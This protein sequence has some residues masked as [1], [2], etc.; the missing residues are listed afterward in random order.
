VGEPGSG[1]ETVARVVH[2]ASAFRDRAFVALDCVGL[3]PYL[4]ES[5]L[6][7]HGGL[8]TSDRVGTIYLKEPA[9]LP[10]DLQQRLADHFA[11]QP[12]TRLICGSTRTAAEAVAAGLLVPVYQ[13]ALSAFEVRVPPLRERLDDLPRLASRILANRALDAAA[14]PVLRAH[15]WP[16]NVRELAAVLAEA[17][18]VG[19]SGP[20]LRDHL[21]LALRVKGEVP[22]TTPAKPMNLDSILEAVEKRMIE[23]ALR[24]TN[25]HQTD[26]AELLGVFRARLGR[27]LEAL[28]I[29]VP[30]QP[31]KPRKGGE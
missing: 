26:A 5:I 14:L 8:G 29:P 31:P 22:R 23:L 20:I 16:G 28:G 6:F 19:A 21:P 1:K 3:Q 27:R 25:N 9:S 12:N 4:I 7:G 18:A 24:K 2:H 17:L 13:T 10:R 15:R 11:E 30:P